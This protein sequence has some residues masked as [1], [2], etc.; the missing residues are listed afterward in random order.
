MDELESDE[1][2]GEDEAAKLKAELENLKVALKQ[3]RGR[4]KDLSAKTE[5]YESERR[6]SL[7]KDV[8]EPF[9]KLLAGKSVD[10]LPEAI[11][12]FQPFFTSTSTGTQEA[13]PERFPVPSGQGASAGHA[14]LSLQEATAL[15]KSDPAAFLKAIGEGRV[16]M[17]ATKFFGASPRR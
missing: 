1:P 7:L 6:T 15:E 2:Q 11:A 10:E 14:R 12:E 5:T 9:Q 13:E 3:E 4:V 8:P 16:D 17:P